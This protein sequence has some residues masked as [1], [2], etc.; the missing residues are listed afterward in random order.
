MTLSSP[1]HRRLG[2]RDV[3]QILQMLLDDIEHIGIG[4][5]PFSAACF[6]TTFSISS[7]ISI[8]TRLFMA[9]IL[10]WPEYTI[11]RH[12]SPAPAL[13]AKVFIL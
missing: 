10:S 2:Q 8:V 5:G 13:A 12:C 11:P 7:G 9:V 6:P 3:V 1:L 4:S